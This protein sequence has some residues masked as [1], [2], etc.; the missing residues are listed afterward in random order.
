MTDSSGRPQQLQ[1]CRQ[2]V[3]CSRCGYRESRVADSLTCLSVFLLVRSMNCAKTA[4]PIGM[5]FVMRNHA[6]DLGLAQIPP[7]EGATLEGISQPVAAY[8]ECPSCFQYSQHC[9]VVSS[10]CYFASPAVAVDS[11]HVI[12]SS[13]SS[14][15][16]FSPPSDFVYRHVSRVWFMVCHWPQSQEGDWARPHLWRLARHMP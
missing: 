8:R 2:R 5:L 7:G 9:S 10:S 11:S 13:S 3:P 15:S 1:Q 14:W 4:E 12:A 6:S 16:I